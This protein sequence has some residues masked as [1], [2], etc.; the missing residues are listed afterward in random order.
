M[1]HEGVSF[2]LATGGPS[3]VKAAYS[4]GTP[5]IGVGSGNAPVLIA[6]DADIQLAAQQIVA[7]KSFDNGLICAPE[8]NLVVDIRIKDAFIDALQAS[9]AAI[10]TPGEA[11]AFMEHCIDPEKNHIKAEFIGKSAAF[12]AKQIG[13]RRDT[14]IKLLVIPTTK[15]DSKDALSHEILLPVLSM[16]TV[17][18]EEEGITLSHELLKI[19]GSGHTAIIY[20]QDADL[21]KRF[22][23]AIPTGRIL[24]NASGVQGSIGIGTGLAPT[25]TL[26]CGTF[27][28][29]STTDNITYQ[30][31]LNRKRIAYY[32][33]EKSQ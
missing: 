20:S 2:I 23:L 29:N 4:S 18:D 24:V 15:V 31:L 1:Q 14:P 13:V 5:A 12:V 3:M 7:S 11:T 17:K 26:G 22:S 33:P 25:M 16:F 19:D 6:Q 30:H 10:L 21:I 32:I 28:G 9:S 27:G 8:H